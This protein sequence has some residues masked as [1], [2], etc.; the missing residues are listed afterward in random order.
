M[1]LLTCMFTILYHVAYNLEFSREAMTNG[2]RKRSPQYKI[3][4]I[5]PFLRSLFWGSFV[6]AIATKV[7]GSSAD[8]LSRQ[9][10][11][12]TTICGGNHLDDDQTTIGGVQ[13]FETHTQKWDLLY[14]YDQH[15]FFHLMYLQH[16]T[17]KKTTKNFQYGI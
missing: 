11:T 10:L 5:L 13:F 12:K 9:P 1:T 14:L 4:K 15:N 3:R 17:D 7:F 8:H 2:S 16:S 6:I